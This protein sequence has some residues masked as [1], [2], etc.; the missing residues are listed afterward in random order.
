MKERYLA[1]FITTD[2]KKKMVF[3]AGPRQVGKTTLSKQIGKE[4]YKEYEYLNWDTLSHRRKIRQE[5]FEDGAELLIFDEIHK[6]RGWKNFI[7]GIF[8]T[9]KEKYHM[10]VTGSARM[11]LYRKGGDSLMGRY[12]SYRLH[13]F[14]VAEILGK[15][16]SKKSVGKQMPL[17]IHPNADIESQAL[18]NYGGFPEPLFEKSEEGLRRWHRQRVDRLLKEDIRDVEVIRDLASC[19]ILMDI[20]PERA[21]S[22]IS[23]ENI[24]E[25]L[26][27]AHSTV[28]FWLSIFEKFYYIYRLSPFQSKRIRALKKEQKLYLWDWSEVIDQSKRLENMIGSHLL[29]L[30]HFL[31]DTMGHQAELMYLRDRD[32]REVDFLVTL[33]R[34]PWFA[35]EVKQSDTTPSRHLN[36]FGERLNIPFLY[37]VVGETGVNFKKNNVHVVSMDRFLSNLV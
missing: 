2:L 33:A 28:S 24:R 7:K 30:C 9:Q 10:L 31:E 22:E 12:F 27:V 4:E 11:D 37:Q 8:D 15:G 23:I 21:G 18:M 3:L 1:P 5:K 20:L 17:L 14:S 34:K 19:Q 25:D 6:Y 13:P 36:Y 35:V 29:K 32:G 26:E 16:F